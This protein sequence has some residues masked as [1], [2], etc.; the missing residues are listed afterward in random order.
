MNALASLNS[1]FKIGTRI[2]FGFLTV[3]VLLLL[4]AAVGY[5]GLH[6]ADGTFDQYVHTSGSS[7]KLLETDRNITNMRRNALA[8]VQSGD[9]AALKRV[10]DMG[11]TVRDDLAAME[12]A[13][14][15]PE[16]RDMIKKIAGL[17]NQFMANFELI[18]QSRAERD[19]A[20]NEVLHPLGGKLRGQISEIVEAAIHANDM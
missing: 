6:S 10:R 5:F 16:R 9:E 3:L 17:V 2:N 20:V 11:K 4:V 15:D 12:A 18:V 14:A 13:T 7:I 8:Y 19:R 1:R